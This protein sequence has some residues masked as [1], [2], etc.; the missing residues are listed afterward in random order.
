MINSKELKLYVIML[1][2]FCMIHK[3]FHIPYHKKNI[4]KKNNKH[5]CKLCA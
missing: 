3:Y 2:L 1:L 5:F 4:S